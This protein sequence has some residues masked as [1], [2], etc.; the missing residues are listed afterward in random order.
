[1]V[2]LVVSTIVYFV[3]AYYIRRYLE[4]E[5]GIEKGMTRGVTVFLGAAAIAYGVAWLIDVA[6]PGQALHLL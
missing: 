4:E 2:S 1:M 6:F 3:A 5:I